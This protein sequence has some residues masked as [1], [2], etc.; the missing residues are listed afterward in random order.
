MALHIMSVFCSHVHLD[1][2]PSDGRVEARACYRPTVDMSGYLF[3]FFLFLY[4]YHK[5]SVT[6]ASN[7]GSNSAAGLIV[8]PTFLSPEPESDGGGLEAAVT[9]GVAVVVD[10]CANPKVTFI[11]PF[12]RLSSSFTPPSTSVIIALYLLFSKAIFLTSSTHPL[13][14]LNF[15]KE[16]LKNYMDFFLSC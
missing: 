11:K 4:R 9:A 6:S 2:F 10:V 15:H 3:D 5:E 13:A 12:T 8:Q 14:V 7:V 16:P 1:R